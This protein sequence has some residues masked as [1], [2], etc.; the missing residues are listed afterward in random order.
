M[1]DCIGSKLARFVAPAQLQ[2]VQSLIADAGS[3][4][5][6]RQCKLRAADGSAVSMQIAVST[7]S[8]DVG[9]SICLLATDLTELELQAGSISTMFKQQLTLEEHKA[10]LQAVNASLRNSRLAALNLMQDAV[11]SRNQLE[12]LTLSLRVSEQRIHQ[13]L[14]VSRSFTFDWQ[15]GT[16]MVIRS[17]SCA[18]ILNLTGDEVVNDTGARFF[19]RIHPDDRA[20]FMKILSALSPDAD[21]YTTEYRIVRAD[22]TEVVLEETGRGNFSVDGTLKR[23]VGVTT[24]ITSRKNTEKA[25]Q[26][27]H[28]ELEHRVAERTAELAAT[29]NTLQLEMWEREVAEKSLRNEIAERLRIMETLREKEQMLL[30][31]SRLAAMGEMINN[32]AHQWRQPLNTLGL[33]IQKLPLFYDTDAFNREFLEENCV[34]SMKQI[35][36]MSQTI[37]DFRDFFR[38]DKEMVMFSLDAVTRQ[39]VAFV[40]QTFQDLKIKIDLDTKKSLMV[41]GYPNEFA[42]VL[43]NI[44]MNARDALVG[45]N[46]ADAR[47]VLRTFKD[48]DS[49]VVTVTDNAGGIPEEVIDMV[50]DPYFTTKGPDKGTGL[51]LFMSKAIIEKNIAGRLTVRNTGN[52]AEFRIE[53][54]HDDN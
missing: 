53:V 37:N 43:L 50:F 8:N 10:E 41:R 11:E 3:G 9:M 29:V 54:A 36:H 4:P 51:G 23:L 24:D 30:Q 5:F 28:E 42:Q 48:G 31:Q 22:G 33:I 2:H 35:Q 21:S 39:A 34:N 7:I 25:L 20:G 13:A 32:I 38:S 26:H 12:E 45:N 49:A 19:Q 1:E 16:D 17:A 46:T 15:P 40:D 14:Q 27:A 47:I 52:G 44:L 18:T 6:Q